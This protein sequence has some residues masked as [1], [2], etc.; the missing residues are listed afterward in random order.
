M[1]S[2]VIKVVRR[3]RAWKVAADNSERLVDVFCTKE[4]AVE[5]ALEL[6][7]ALSSRDRAGG[8]V[9]VSVDDVDRTSIES[10]VP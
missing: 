2:T 4:R 7:R 1:S 3:G 5:H 6:A 10:Y 9:T 8:D